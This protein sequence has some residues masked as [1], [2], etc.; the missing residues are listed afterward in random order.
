MSEH[1]RLFIIG[2]QRSGTSYL[3]RM[4]DEHPDIVMAKPMRPEPKFFLDEEMAERGVAHYDETYFA[5]ETHEPVRGEKSTSYIESPVA[6]KRIAQTFPNAILVAALR[7]PIDR[8]VSNYWFSVNNK[9]ETRSLEDA[10]HPN[11]TCPIPNYDQQLSV[12]PF[13]YLQRGHYIDQLR[14]YTR[15]FPHNQIVILLFEEFTR[16]FSVIAA[17][18]RRLNVSTAF[19]PP[20]HAQPVNASTPDT[21]RAITPALRTKLEDYFAPFNARLAAHFDLDLSLWES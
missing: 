2:A 4:L 20:H 14:V 11:S 6:A 9:L 5:D 19:V 17:L 13:A 8:A 1:Q 15:F 12:S 10:L 7:N 21:L 18:Y 16:D 3:Y